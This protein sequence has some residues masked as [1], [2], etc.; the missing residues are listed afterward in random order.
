MNANVAIQPLIK[1]S[2]WWGSAAISLYNGEIAWEIEGTG[3][4]QRIYMLRGDGQP[5][6][7]SPAG[8][9]TRLRVNGRSFLFSYDGEDKP[10]NEIIDTIRD[11]IIAET[12][13]AQEAESAIAETLN[14]EINRATEADT[15][16]QEADASLNGKATILDGEEG[17]E[18]GTLEGVTEDD[19]LTQKSYTDGAIISAVSIE[20]SRATGRENELEAAI[21]EAA[22]QN[23]ET[24]APLINPHFI[25]DPQ[26]ANPF[27]SAHV[28]TVPD[29]R[30][31]AGGEILQGNQPVPAKRWKDLYD[32][33]L[34][35]S[36][37]FLRR[38]DKV[39]GTFEEL[40]LVDAVDGC[41][42]YREVDNLIINP[43]D[44]VTVDRFNTLYDLVVDS[45][46]EFLRAGDGETRELRLVDVTEGSPQAYREIDRAVSS[47]G[48]M[49]EDS[50]FVYDF[51]WID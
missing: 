4:Q 21:T 11:T 15:A 28:I 43:D 17:T 27:N 14:Q 18:T 7:G 23:A 16:L 6:I 36:G 51:S 2:S 32:L 3:T 34:E 46:G 13:R 20:N 50:M 12:Q 19:P 35:T 48:G 47:G 22:Q 10:V 8:D 30:F 42:Y 37:V 9:Y 1:P 33:T 44:Y 39:D 38:A 31:D 26:E 40:L 45:A 24:Y 49:S 25:N 41:K 5:V 29:L